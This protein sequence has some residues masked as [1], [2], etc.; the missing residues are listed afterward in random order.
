[1]GD[2]LVSIVLPTYRR[3]GKL[4]ATIDSV[5]RQT[6]A[7][8]ELIVVDDNHP[9]D[10]HSRET[11]NVIR[12]YSDHSNV[13][14]ITHGVN[15]GACAARNTGITAAKGEYIAFLDD[16]D[17]WATNKLELQVAELRKN[18]DT[19]FVFC[20]LICVDSTD[21]T[22]KRVK[23]GLSKDDL[24]RDLLKRGGGICTSALMI[25]KDIL[26]EIGGFDAS[27]PSYQDYDLLLRLALRCKH[28]A[29]DTP[30]LDYNVSSDGISRNYEAKFRGKK[31]IIDKYSN[32]FRDSSLAAYYGTHLEV[33]GDYAVL[34]GRRWVAIRYYAHAISKR[35]VSVS[36]YAKLLVALI[37]GETLYRRASARYQKARQLIGSNA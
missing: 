24:F 16:D 36:P 25:R 10:T 23:F 31:I 5:F 30:L 14:L 20:D 3:A 6:Y 32:Y 17:T 8:W 37:G 21:N 22:R 29:I 18:P 1:M 26:L 33:L 4:K 13:V 34:H 2:A 7:N 9:S 19:G 28:A 11:E 27:L 15:K 12:E 35:A